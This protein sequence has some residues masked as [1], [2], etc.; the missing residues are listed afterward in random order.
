[1]ADSGRVN[2][3]FLLLDKQIGSEN[4]IGLTEFWVD[5]KDVNLKRKALQMIEALAEGKIVASF[6]EQLDEVFYEE[7]GW[8]VGDVFSGKILVASEPI[9]DSKHGGEVW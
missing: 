8:F 1:M 5:P 3:S 2:M 4:V 9:D 7:S 6:V